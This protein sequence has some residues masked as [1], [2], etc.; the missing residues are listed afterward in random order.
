MTVSCPS[1]FN[2]VKPVVVSSKPNEPL[3]LKCPI[4]ECQQ[5]FDYRPGMEIR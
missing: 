1:C 3:K 5:D 4:E 2:P